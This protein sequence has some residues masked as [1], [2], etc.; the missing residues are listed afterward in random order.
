MSIEH[1]DG[2]LG[3]EEGFILGKNYLRLW[4]MA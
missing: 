4:A 1:E 3:R 2:A